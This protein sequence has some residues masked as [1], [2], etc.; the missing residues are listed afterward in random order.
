MAAG[1]HAP[2]GVDQQARPKLQNAGAHSAGVLQQRSKVR[3]RPTMAIGGFA[4]AVAIG[5]ITLYSHKKP[6]ATALDVA[7]VVTGV[8]GPEHT[9]PRN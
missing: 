4:V 7:K 9:R 5:Y 8:A 3:F 1:S 2:A 6:E